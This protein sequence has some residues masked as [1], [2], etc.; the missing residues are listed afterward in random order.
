MGAPSKSAARLLSADAG[1]LVRFLPNA[2]FNGTLRLWYHAWDQTSGS[3][4]GT[5]PIAGNRGGMKTLST[6]SESVSL[7]VAAVNDKPT[8]TFS[9]TI[10][11]RLNSAPVLLAPYAIVADVDSAN[12]AGGQLRIRID[13]GAGVSNR[14]SLGPGF[15]VDANKNVVKNGLI[16]GKRTSSGF[17]TS[18][19]VITLYSSA[20]KVLVQQLA[21]SITFKT[22][23]GTAEIRRITFSISDVDGGL[24]AEATKSVLAN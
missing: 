17:G 6:A 3:S 16:I 7:T 4:G 22:V 10:G 2:N 13:E 12:F 24:S 20:T 18:E 15:T 23:S 8:L 9:S 1:A 11:Y 5:L 21:R 14:L 19:L